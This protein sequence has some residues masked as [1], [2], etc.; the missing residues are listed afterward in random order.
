MRSRVP[1]FWVM[2]YEIGWRPMRG[3]RWGSASAAA[4]SF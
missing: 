2:T 4:L 3:G 1:V